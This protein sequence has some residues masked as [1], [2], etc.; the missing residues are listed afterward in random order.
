M[1]LDNRLSA[2]RDSLE[3]ATADA[4]PDVGDLD[5]P[6]RR[7]RVSAITFAVVSLTVVGVAAIALVPSRGADDVPTASGAATTQEAAA[8]VAA[9]PVEPSAEPAFGLPRAATGWDLVAVESLT[10][11]LGVAFADEEF[12]QLAVTFDD[13]PDPL[14]QR[15]G[16]ITRT[17]RVG[18]G[19]Y[20]DDLRAVYP[21]PGAPVTVGSRS[22]EVVTVDQPTFTQSALVPVDLSE[23]T[24]LITAR[25]VDVETLTDLA[26]S[27][28]PSGSTPRL[29]A[30]PAGFTVIHS[31]A[32]EFPTLDSGTALSYR[33]PTDGARSLTITTYSGP[34]ISC[35]AYAWVHDGTDIT[36]IG[37]DAGVVAQR[38]G[39][40]RQVGSYEA[41]WNVDHRTLIGITAAGVTRAELVALADQLVLDPEPIDAYRRPLAFA[42]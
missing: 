37:G 42:L 9:V 24:F 15:E 21:G 12:T 27:I 40:P 41:L 36:P 22:F 4:R 25:G 16:T 34:P 18:V 32:P 8:A 26:A 2:A 7:R 35:F 3:I 5:R 38:S 29:G 19:A 11:D 6:P 10:P 33:D 31:G 23:R 20:T 30:P 14:T 28:D 17:I 1:N 13:D 39:E